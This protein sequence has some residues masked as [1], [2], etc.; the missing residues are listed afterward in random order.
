[1]RQRSPQ[2]VTMPFGDA[3]ACR[4]PWW[5][6][7]HHRP[8]LAHALPREH[9]RSVLM[10][11]PTLHPTDERP[12]RSADAAARMPAYDRRERTGRRA[13]QP[14]GE[15]AGAARLLWA[16]SEIGRAHV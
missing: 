12:A 7:T 16:R 8:W 15:R 14:A 6:T 10:S 11:G 9:A 4:V 5:R 2:R 3:S 1:M 13:P